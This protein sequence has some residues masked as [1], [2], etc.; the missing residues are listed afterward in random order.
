MEIYAV[1]ALR[2]IVEVA[3]M[4]LLGQGF[5]GLF[6]GA[7]RG[8]NPIYRLFQIVSA[9]VL[10]VFRHLAPRRIIDRH[11]PFLAFFVLFWLWILL[12]YTK[13]LLCVDGGGGAACGV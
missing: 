5:V 3:L 11:L 7:G 12:A 9:P 6:A 10:Q 2:A 13:R 1:S 4:S 8:S